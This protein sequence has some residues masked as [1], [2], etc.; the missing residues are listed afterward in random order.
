MKK[1]YKSE[2]D[3]V[4]TGVIGGIAEYY[5]IDSTI[6]RL[7][8]IL[9]VILTGIVPGIIGYI[10]A[11]LVVPQRSKVSPVSEAVSSEPEVK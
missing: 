2:K 10:I 7:I 11:S 3:N 5:E 4:L 8:Y 1:L 6:L 9:I